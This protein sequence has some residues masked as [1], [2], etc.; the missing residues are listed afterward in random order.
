MHLGMH[1]GLYIFQKIAVVKTLIQ[2][3][4]Y[5]FDKIFKLGFTEII[6]FPAVVF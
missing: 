5:A 6:F 3:L 1:M 2:G 4:I